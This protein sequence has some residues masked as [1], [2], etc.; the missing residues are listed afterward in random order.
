MEELAKNY[1]LN[2][3][4]RII[5]DNSPIFAKMNLLNRP[6]RLRHLRGFLIENE[7]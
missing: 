2:D 7:K 3:R 1:S 4:E 6:V 5:L